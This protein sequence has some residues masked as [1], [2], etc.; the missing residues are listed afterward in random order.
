MHVE[1]EMLE[2]RERGKEMEW[3]VFLSIRAVR[4]SGQ[5]AVFE[6]RLVSR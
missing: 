6:G 1:I 4:P 5:V 3:A 2:M